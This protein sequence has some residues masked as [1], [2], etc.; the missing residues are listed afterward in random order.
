VKTCGYSAVGGKK[1]E[2]L[3]KPLSN[4]SNSRS[5]HN[6][7]AESNGDFKNK[8]AGSSGD[9]QDITSYFTKLQMEEQTKGSEK[10]DVEYKEEDLNNSTE[11]FPQQTEGS[12]ADE[13]C[14]SSQLGSTFNLQDTGDASTSQLGSTL[15][16]DNT[17]TTFTD[18]KDG[19]LN[20][21]NLL[22]GA[23]EVTLK[24]VKYIPD[25]L[26]RRSIGTCELIDGKVVASQTMDKPY[27]VKL[28]NRKQGKLIFRENLKPKF[29]F[30]KPQP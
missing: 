7:T 6:S 18:Y 14:G 24:S 30:E 28:F 20:F 27:C 10:V 12:Q 25:L 8:T 22:N 26:L 1:A 13:S 2:P 21:M 11:T 16:L 17:T 23:G 3:R 4:I 9:F 5:I 29:P 19:E 15:D